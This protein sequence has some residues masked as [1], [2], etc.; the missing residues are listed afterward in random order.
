LPYFKRM[1][2]CLAGADEYRGGDG[3]LVLERGSAASPLFDA[4]FEAVKQA[5]Y[6]LTDDVNGRRQEGF[7]KFDRTI[8][9]GRRLSAARAYLHPVRNR[10]N[11]EVRC[12][13]FVKSSSSTERAPWGRV[14]E[15]GRTHVVRRRGDP[16][17]RRDQSRSCSAVRRRQRRGAG[18]VEVVHDLPESAKTSGPPRG[19]HPVLVPSGLGAAGPEEWGDRS[20]A[21]S[22]SSSERT[23]AMNHF[24]A[25][26]SCGRTTTSP[27]RTSCSISSRSRSATTARLPSGKHGYRCTSGRC[28]PTR[29]AR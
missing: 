23:G 8:Y 25:A 10:L 24:E 9:R 2:T 1:E 3:P 12:R 20:S 16:L 27:T 28:T 14:A 18:G 7:A 5:G 22:G 21:R 6:E 17:R 11:L 13:A 29:A 4:F 19:L 26:G 15:G